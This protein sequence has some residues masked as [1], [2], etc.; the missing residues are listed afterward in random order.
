MWNALSL[1]VMIAFNQFSLFL[2]EKINIENQCCDRLNIFIESIRLDLIR[3]V[4]FNSSPATLYNKTNEL[5]F[6]MV[7]IVLL[8]MY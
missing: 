6:K 8:A 3:S 1:D 5:V 4:E 2:I 7:G